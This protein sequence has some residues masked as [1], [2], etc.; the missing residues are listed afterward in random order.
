MNIDTTAQEKTLNSITNI[1][2]NATAQSSSLNAAS[3]TSFMSSNWITGIIII[4]ILAIFGINVFAYLAKG[5][6]DVASIFNSIFGPIVQVSEKIIKLF[7][8]TGLEVT[9]KIIN[10][11]SEGAK[12]GIDIV[13]NTST[14]T[15]NAIESVTQG[16]SSSSTSLSPIIPN[17]T[18]TSINSTTT[19]SAITATTALAEEDDIQRTLQSNSNNYTSTVMPDD[20]DSSI[21]QSGKS[22]WRYI[23]KDN[24]IR[25]CSQ[26]GVNDTCMSGDIYTSREICMDPTLRP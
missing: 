1:N 6:D 17:K 22:G 13:N 5:T 16:A 24:G 23:G 2:D 9:K 4:F 10:V 26:I 25:A 3:I 21:Q 20:T 19:A 7:T 14:G 15:I 11:S 18:P 12:A 8:F